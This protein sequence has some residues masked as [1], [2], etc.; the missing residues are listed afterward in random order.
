VGQRLGISKQGTRALTAAELIP[1]VRDHRGYNWNRAEATPR[2]SPAPVTRESRIINGRATRSAF[3]AE[4]A[5][6]S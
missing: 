4:R 5:A 6:T 1:A 3:A 2:W